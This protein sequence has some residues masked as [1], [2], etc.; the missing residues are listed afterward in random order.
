MPIRLPAH[1]RARTVPNK[2]CITFSRR[3]NQKAGHGIDSVLQTFTPL[4]DPIEGG[5]HAVRKRCFSARVYVNKVDRPR[6]GRCEDSKI[7]PFGN[8]G[9]NVLSVFFLGSS[10]LDMSA[11]ALNRGFSGTVVK[12]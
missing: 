12:R 10:P 9:L 2:A 3:D 4:E 5:S 6:A 8:N 11:L 1:F 7:M